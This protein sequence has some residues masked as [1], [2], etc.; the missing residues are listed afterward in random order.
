MESVL[1]LEHRDRLIDAQTPVTI[2][3]ASRAVETDILESVVDR[4]TG[5]H[6]VAL[7]ICPEVES[8][9]G[10]ELRD[11]VFVASHDAPAATA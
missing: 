11:L 3:N 10:T 2:R 9:D 6:L 5:E 8:T 7:R 4:G 1:T